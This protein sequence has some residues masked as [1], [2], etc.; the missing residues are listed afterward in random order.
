MSKSNLTLELLKLALPIVAVNLA[1]ALLGTTDTLFMGR[2]GSSAVAGVGLGALTYYA[3]FLL[4]RSTA[5]AV[6]VFVSRSYGAGDL[7]AC[8]TWLSRFLWL[9][10]GLSLL[11]PV[12]YFIFPPILNFFHPQPD[13]LHAA[14]TFAQ[15]RVLEIPFAL[16]SAVLLGFRLG[17]GDSKTPMYV[18]WFT[19]VLNIFFSYTLVFGNFGFPVLGIQ[20]AALGTVISVAI[21]TIIAAFIVLNAK[22]RAKYKIHFQRPTLETLKNMLKIG[23]PLGITEFVEVGAFAAFTAV[24]GR[25]GTIELAASQISNQIASL[26]FMPGFALG[27]GTGSLVGRYLGAKDPK[28]AAAVGYLGVRLGMI[29]MGF[30]GILFF[31]IPQVLVSGFNPE[32]KVLELSTQLMKLMALYQVFDASGIIFR[33]A[34]SGAGDTRFPMIVTLIG[35]WIVMVGGAILLTQTFHL[36]LLGA[37]GGAFIYVCA[38]GFMFWM[39]WRAGHWQHMNL[40]HAH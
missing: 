7:A 36:G 8:G 11:T 28:L 25:V 9:A 4:I 23:L 16:I 39:R 35:S 10:L 27:I 5:G 21:Q 33:G 24:I 18:T 26:G 6:T 34:L 40:E 37:W 38:M 22:D 17:V 20:G 3:L 15:I 13:A 30:V 1:Y 12:F 2:L 29:W 14:I 31:T 19:V 32:P